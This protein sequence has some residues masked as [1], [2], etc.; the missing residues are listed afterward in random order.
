LLAEASHG[1]LQQWIRNHETPIQLR[2]RWCYQIT[3]AVAYIHSHGVIHSDLRPDNIL[4]HDAGKGSLDLWLCDFGSST[5]AK[6]GI[7][8]G[9]LP[10]PG[11]F[12]PRLDA[13]PTPATNIFSLG[14]IFYTVVT[15]YWPFR[16]LNTPFKTHDDFISYYKLVDG[17]FL[18]GIFPLIE[19]DL[20]D[21]IMGCWTHRFT[22]ADDVL[23]ALKPLLHS[24]D[25]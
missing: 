18:Q 10:D 14:S 13:T 3:E 22:S 2:P 25:A 4:V 17:S 12:D 21:V 15:G 9:H 23:H 8:G 7:H 11:F 24:Q 6:L 20:G 5:C 19:G 1:S 16:Q